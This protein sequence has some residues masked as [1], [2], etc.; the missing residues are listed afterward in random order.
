MYIYKEKHSSSSLFSK[1]DIISVDK[2]I[3]SAEFKRGCFFAGQLCGHYLRC[4]FFSVHQQ[5]IMQSDS[6]SWMLGPSSLTRRH[7]SNLDFDILLQ[8]SVLTLYYIVCKR[9]NL[10]D[11]KN[12]HD[13]LTLSHHFIICEYLMP[14]FQVGFTRFVLQHWKNVS[15]QVGPVARNFGYITSIFFKKCH[16]MFCQLVD[17]AIELMK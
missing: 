4:L 5:L 9:C 7:V 6:K 3:Y 11:L 17:L 2:L 10:E 8:K 14:N 16:I 13:V 12:V 1:S 15:L